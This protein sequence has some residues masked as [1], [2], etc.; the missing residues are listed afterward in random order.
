MYTHSFARNAHLLPIT[1]AVFLRNFDPT[2]SI[3]SYSIM[4]TV[5]RYLIFCSKC[6]HKFPIFA[7]LPH[8][9]DVNTW[10]KEKSDTHDC[11]AYN[12][13]LAKERAPRPINPLK[14]S[15]KG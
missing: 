7:S 8:T 11:K 12:D 1:G 13:Q 4:A 15:K 14:A 5:K 6:N 2:F 9:I 3:R 10:I